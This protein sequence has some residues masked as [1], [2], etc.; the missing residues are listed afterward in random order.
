MWRAFLAFACAAL[1]AATPAAASNG[2]LASVLDQRLVTVNPDGSGLRTLWTPG[3]PGLG[4]LPWSPDGK[5][6]ALSHNGEIAVWDLAPGRGTTIPAGT[7]PTCAA[8][9]IGRR[10]RLTRAAGSPDARE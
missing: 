5:R 10:R 8:G 2:M 3:A 1:L 6:L 7:D 4:G 9:G